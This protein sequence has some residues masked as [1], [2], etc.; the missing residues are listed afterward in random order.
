MGVPVKRIHSQYTTDLSRLDEPHEDLRGK[1]PVYG[2]E[3]RHLP[4]SNE[5]HHDQA[6]TDYHRPAK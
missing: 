1:A 2:C 6:R 3:F 4:K 5:T